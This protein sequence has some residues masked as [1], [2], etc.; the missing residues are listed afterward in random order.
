MRILI[1]CGSVTQVVVD[2]I[3]TKIK[4]APQ[5]CAKIEPKKDKQYC[6]LHECNMLHR[7]HTQKH[8]LA[9]VLFPY[10]DHLTVLIFIE[11]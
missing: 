1:L 4:N 3:E 11:I 10:A 6:T 8:C 2:L 7:N 5:N 9:D